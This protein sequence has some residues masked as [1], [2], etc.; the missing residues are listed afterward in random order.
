MIRDLKV[1]DLKKV[2]NPTM[3]ETHTD[4]RINTEKALAHYEIMFRLGWNIGAWQTDT[5]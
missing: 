3:T 2:H 1:V 4:R 5:S